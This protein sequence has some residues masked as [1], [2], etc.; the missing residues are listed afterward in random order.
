MEPSHCRGRHTFNSHRPPARAPQRFHCLLSERLWKEADPCLM[1]QGLP[2]EM[3]DQWLSCTGIPLLDLG[4]PRRSRVMRWKRTQGGLKGRHQW[5][6]HIKVSVT[7]WTVTHQAPLFMQFLSQ[8]YWNGLP[9][10]SPGNLP[11]SRIEPMSSALAGEFFT[12]K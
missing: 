4:S 8:E 9:F 10:S 6:N 7:P 5:L 11:N 3:T 2:G 12:A 1:A